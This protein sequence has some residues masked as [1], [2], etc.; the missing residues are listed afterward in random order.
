MM[1]CPGDG[2][3]RNKTRPVRLGVVVIDH[4][5][6]SALSNELLVEATRQVGGLEGLD[7]VEPAHMD[8]AEPTLGQAFDRC[9]A[10]GVGTVVI[11]PF[12]LLPGRHWQEDIPTLAEA[13]GARHPGVR[14]IITAPLG[15]HPLMALIVEDRVRTCLAC[16][17]GA[18]EPCET[19]KLVGGCRQR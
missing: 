17:D 7:V 16:A 8:L 9:V 14:W 18:G 5:S 15:L 12:F 4:G 3:D 6:R 11:V 2:E 13:A 19:C 10:R 1:E